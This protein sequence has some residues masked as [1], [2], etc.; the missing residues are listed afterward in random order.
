MGKHGRARQRKSYKFMDGGLVTLPDDSHVEMLGKGKLYATRA[1]NVD[2]FRIGSAQ[3]S[4]GWDN[5][6]E[7]IAGLAPY[8]SNPLGNNS[9]LTSVNGT[10]P[11]EIR[12][13]KLITP[14]S[15]KSVA[16]VEFYG[17]TKE[18]TGTLYARIRADNA[19]EPG[20][21]ITD[22]ESIGVPVANEPSPPFYR[23]LYFAT[24]PALT[25]GTDYWLSLEVDVTAYQSLPR[26]IAQGLGSSTPGSSLQYWLSGAWES[27]GASSSPYLKVL[28]STPP[29][30]GLWDT[31][32]FD[33]AN[34][35][36]TQFY[37]AA[38]SGGL[39]AGDPDVVDIGGTWDDP[40]ATGLAS[41]ADKLFDRKVLKNL[42]FFTDYAQHNN[43]V[44]DGFDGTDRDAPYTTASRDLSTMTHGYR[45][46]FEAADGGVTGSGTTWGGT[47]FPNAYTSILAVTALKSGGYRTRV[48][49]TPLAA[50]NSEVD[51]TALGITEADDEFYF[52][53][54]PLA[55][56]WYAT[57]PYD[58]IG[59]AGIFY[60]IPAA[61]LSGG[62]NPTANS[63]AAF[64]IYPCSD[65]DLT[66]GGDIERLL[67]IP[68]RY[69]TL[70][71]DTPKL[72]GLEVF[73]SMLAGWG[74]PENPSRVWIAEQGAP[75]VFG[76]YGSTLGSF[77]DVA[78]ED[79]EF[80]TGIK[81]V[82]GNTL[83]VAKQHNLYRVDYTGDVNEPFRTERVRGF[84]GCLSH[85]AM[86]SIP[87]GLYFMSE[88]GPAVCYGTFSKLLP[89]TDNIRN[90]FDRGSDDR[91]EQTGL[92]YAVSCNDPTR[93]AIYTTVSS[94]GSSLRDQVLVYEYKNQQFSIMENFNA[95]VIASI[96]DAN[97]FPAVWYGD[98]QGLA[99][100]QNVDLEDTTNG[101]S[102]MP[103]YLDTPFLELGD[104][105][106]RK[107]GAYAWLY[108]EVPTADS[109]MT[110]YVDVMIDGSDTVVQTLT[111]PATTSAECAALRKGVARPIAPIFRSIKLAIRTTDASKP[112]AI[113]GLDIDFTFEGQDL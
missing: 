32:F 33:S 7:N 25:S 79:G 90:L 8:I 95:N 22:G 11:T 82:G 69:F 85:W 31:R 46:A 27:W 104:G 61:R 101:G 28:A 43:R 59:G 10:T 42:A 13:A 63:N 6:G 35:E 14:A 98:Y 5:I 94:R 71:V 12:L 89:A 76:T 81:T 19:G 73:A 56:T 15:S 112:L 64:Q 92:A 80:V 66:G 51:I 103:M 20:A 110:I 65:A 47:G 100:K 84:L 77:V 17:V 34:S 52:D 68:T 44:W 36:L 86:E 57:K 55:T 38:C 102:A 78:P 87:E 40:I 21:V 97:A 2:F 3:K 83:Y 29:V 16:S 9:S 106:Q 88:L 4:R 50:N 70:Q 75:Q 39:Y 96:S 105:A 24:P 41:A 93:G 54:D 67:G 62:A 91:F 49:E 45:P 26:L 48:V 107:S 58:E 111:Y 1:T 72:K 99:Y 108:A 60:K 109:T 113:S 18:V 37:T 53:I 23:T 30:L 74:D